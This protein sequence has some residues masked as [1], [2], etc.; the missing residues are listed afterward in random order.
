MTRSSDPAVRKAADA[1]FT[2]VDALAEKQAK[3]FE[4]SVPT[5]RVVRLRGMHYV[6]LSNERD[7]LR[8]M[9]AFLA[10]LK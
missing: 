3:A 2:T 9:R 8:E 5:A 1:Y 6:F 7:V 4:D 10:G